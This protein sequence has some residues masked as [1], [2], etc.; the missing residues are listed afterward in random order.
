MIKDILVNLPVDAKRD[1]A[2]DFAVSLAGAFNAHLAAIA[3]VHRPIVPGS[4]LDGAAAGIIQA[5]RAAAKEAAQAAIAK[6][7]ETARRN[8]LSAESRWV[9]SDY[10][11]I[12][13]L[14]ARIARQFDIS[15]V[16]QA[17]PDAVG[18]E[19]LIVEAALFDSGRPVL[20]VPYIQKTPLKLGRAMACWDGSRSAARAIAD[21]LPFLARAKAVE[22]L[23]V[24]GEA[25]KS[26]ELEGTDIAHHLARHG[27]KVEVE[28]QV[29][30][31]IDVAS[32]ILSRVADT[33]ADLIVMGGYGH[34]RLREFVLGGAT[35]G[36]LGSMTVPVLM[37]H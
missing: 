13:D 6:F 31:D 27:V 12:G 23:T 30:R 25:G 22:I 15:V 2:T 3:F 1:V 20:I 21:A 7:E 24:T 8:A 19:R 33:N 34:S 16:A 17:E 35:R 29:A 32:V 10:A 4:L 18:P 5:Q 9:D 37:S 11:G 14:F 26:S 28:R 36:I